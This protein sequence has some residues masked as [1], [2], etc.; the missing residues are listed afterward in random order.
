MYFLKNNSL[1]TP[2]KP[3]ID[4]EINNFNFLNSSSKL[5][6]YVSLESST[7]YE[8][9]DDTEDEKYGYAISEEAVSTIQNDFT[10]IFSWSENAS[11]DGV[12]KL[13]NASALATDDYD[14]NDQK[15][16]LIYPQG[17]YIIHDPK[18]G[19]EG[20]LIIKTEQFS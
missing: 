3:K 18:I 5:T 14:S 2:T 20:I 10:G 7:P 6:L 11:V 17:T 15:I 12:T 13:I 16:Y 19:L 8:E 1:I 4:I 9:H